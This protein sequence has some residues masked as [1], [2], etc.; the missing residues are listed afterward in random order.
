LFGKAA[1]NALLSAGGRAE[2]P[3]AVAD[4]RADQQGAFEA[5]VEQ[6]IHPDTGILFH[7]PQLAEGGSAIATCPALA[8]AARLDDVEEEHGE[9]MED[10]IKSVAGCEAVGQTMYFDSCHYLVGSAAVA[11]RGGR[12]TALFTFTL[13]DSPDSPQVSVSFFFLPICLCSCSS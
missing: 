12:N 5:W 7:D 13:S 9:R 4:E 6:I 10:S 3:L 2:L 8:V 11:K 1:Q